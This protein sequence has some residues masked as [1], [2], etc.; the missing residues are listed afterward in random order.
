M[1]FTQLRSFHA[2]ATERGFTAASKVLNVGQPTLTSQVRAL[3]EMFRVELF[4]RRGREIELTEAGEALIVITRRIMNL[5]GEARDVLNAFGGFHT[6][7]LHVGAVGPYH[8]TEMLS[9]FSEKYP[10]VRLAVKVGNSREMVEQ[11][12]NYSVDVAVL[13]HVEDD[14]HIFAMPYSRHKV[15]VFVNKSHPFAKRRKIRISDLDG[16]RMVLRERGSTTR[17]AFEDA[18]KRHR[19]KINPVMEIGSREAVWLAVVRGIGIG[20]VS[21]IEYI[22]HPNLHMVEVSDADIYTTAH[23]NCLMERRSSRLIDAFFDVA[24]TTNPYKA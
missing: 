21:E 9:A 18:L 17:L 6:G 15:V 13:A 20:V 16:E 3:E 12:L 11:L 5:E 19:V 1:I 14:P 24:A 2:V 22:E 8:A 4:H 23:V 7:T 10:G